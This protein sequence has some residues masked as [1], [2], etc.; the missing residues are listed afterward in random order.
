MEALKRCPSWGA[1]SLAEILH[2]E[3]DLLI[4]FVQSQRL[5]H[6]AESI[7]PYLP[8]CTIR[9]RQRGGERERERKLEWVKREKARKCESSF[10]MRGNTRLL[11]PK[12]S[13][14]LNVPRP[15][16]YRLL[17][18]LESTTNPGFQGF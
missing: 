3:H 16:S 1:Q 12:G 11:H 15:L 18:G 9:E 8:S 4:R 6:V 13:N 14:P 2:L 5:G 10:M 17:P 7:F